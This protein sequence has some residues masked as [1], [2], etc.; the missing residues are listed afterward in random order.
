[1][2]E[3]LYPLNLIKKNLTYSLFLGLSYGIVG[4]GLAVLLFPEDPAIVAV[5]LISLLSY[6]TI[7]NLMKEEEKIESKKEEF[8]IFMFLKDHKYIFII[9]MLFFIGLLLA[10]SIFSLMLPSLA[11][12][13][14]F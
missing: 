9:Y 11:T 4:I 3:Q 6:P 5:A 14:I 2:L 12:N 10:F 13:H 8:N 1:M 7:S